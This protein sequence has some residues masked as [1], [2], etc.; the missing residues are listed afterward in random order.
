MSENQKP[1]RV[2]KFGGSSVATA[3]RIRNVVDIIQA[4]PETVQPIV[5]VSAMG[6]VTS[7]LRDAIEAALK[8]TETHSSIVEELRDR[9]QEALEQLVSDPEERQAVE[10]ILN[11][12][13]HELGELLDGVYLLRECTARS[14]DAIISMGERT[15]VPLVT[16]ALRGA[17]GK[18]KPFEATQFIRTDAQFGSANVDIEE[19]NRLVEETF[20]ELAADTAAVVTGF[21]GATSEGVTT[22]LGSSGSDYSATILARALVAD[23]VE[24][25]T[26][27]DGILSADPRMVPEAFPLEQLNYR[28]AGELA[29]F[30]AEVLHPRTMQP[31]KAD[32][33]PLLIKN[34]MNPD[35]VGT[36]ISGVS[37]P[38]SGRVKAVTSIRDTALIIVEGTGM[39]G[40]PGI[41]ARVFGAL[42]E[43]D[44]NV[45]M[46]S[47]ASSEQSICFVIRQRQ[48]TAAVRALRKTFAAELERGD[49]SDIHV[50]KNV[51]I[52]AAVGDSMRNTPGIAGPMF[53]ALRRSKINVL[54]IAE[55]ASESNLSVVVD[56]ED[57]KATLDVLHQ[58][59]S[60]SRHR[61]HLVLLGTGN[62]GT[63]F[64][65]T[66]DRQA[67]V[68]AD[69]SNL[70]LRL[71]GVANT[72]SIAWNERGLPIDEALD[73]MEPRSSGDLD[74]LIR[75]LTHCQLERLI[76]IDATASEEIP[77]RYPELLKA[78]VA[79]ATPNKRA[80]TLELP[81]FENLRTLSRDG[82]PYEYE[83]T[84]GA[85]LPVLSTLHNLMRTGDRV[86][87]VEGVLSGTLGFVLHRLMN[88][89]SFSE[90]VREAREKGY[91]EPD[92]REDLSGEDVA[93][94]LLILAREM[95]HEVERSDVQVESLIPDELTDVSLDAFMDRLS[96]VDEHWNERVT[97]CRE[98][99]QRLQYL[100]TI[101]ADAISVGVRAVDADTPFARLQGTENMVAF[102]T[103]RY[104]ETPLVVQGPGAGAEVT[105]AGLLADVV[106]A[107]RLMA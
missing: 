34:T 17:D 27:V 73:T 62:I 44:I 70:E 100:G 11:A 79:I 93:R 25:W 94:K 36:R 72:D 96:V 15:S 86:H 9:H 68:L 71:I 47:Q 91:S 31:L 64:L 67:E 1:Y 80:N 77:R 41:A 6:G 55:G 8:R 52:V 90:A 21:I 40:V 78:G 54:A 51:A 30:G 97:R 45:L 63:N 85:G 37:T 74:E 89:V 23:Q 56:D 24:I 32:R 103:D 98:N 14:R 104:E 49:I 106:K 59:Y 38:G 76:L 16:A 75:R 10:T 87:R 42:A 107:A 2:L 4:I 88:G 69:E 53:S 50:Q 46:I 105:A 20:S 33:I 29:Y 22:T 57:V 35:A 60:L 26:D 28:E 102:T 13:W 48:S 18:A 5:V 61:A 3:D 65:E 43:K 101:T 82:V 92:P 83:T 7:R 39:L 19:T 58:T 84:V 81:F 99:G 95:G 12:R 66:L